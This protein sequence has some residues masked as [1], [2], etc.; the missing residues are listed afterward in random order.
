MASIV[1]STLGQCDNL[2]DEGLKG[3]AERCVQLKQLVIYGSYNVT[4]AG[5]SRVV[6]NC[7][8]LRTLMMWSLE[9]I[10]GDGWLALVPARLPHLRLLSLIGS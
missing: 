6:H 10:T 2:Y 8:Q 4:D 5:V 9:H 3:V 1:S 7:S